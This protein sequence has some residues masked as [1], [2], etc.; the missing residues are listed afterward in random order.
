MSLSCSMPS[1]SATFTRRHN[2]NNHLVTRHHKCSEPSHPD[3]HLYQTLLPRDRS[4]CNTIEERKDRARLAQRRYRFVKRSNAQA[5]LMKSHA[6]TEKPDPKPDVQQEHQL[7]QI[8]T[9]ASACATICRSLWILMPTIGMISPLHVTLC[10]RIKT[11]IHEGY[12]TEE[13]LAVCVDSALHEFLEEY[14]A[15][16]AERS[17]TQKHSSLANLCTLRR[18]TGIAQAELRKSISSWHWSEKP[19]APASLFRPELRRLGNKFLY[20][21]IDLTVYMSRYGDWQRSLGKDPDLDSS[22]VDLCELL[23]CPFAHLWNRQEVFDGIEKLVIN[24]VVHMPDCN[25]SS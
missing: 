15:C 24:Y 8:S 16:K 11:A 12:K 18:H 19:R 23:L 1:C 17:D 9:A 4:R 25:F 13:C 5:E 22:F 6:R 2:L 10:S 21:Y 14:K 7:Q 20:F 3:H